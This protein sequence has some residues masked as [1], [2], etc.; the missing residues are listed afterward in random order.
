VFLWS[1]RRN[2]QL[3]SWRRS[4]IVISFPHRGTTLTE[5]RTQHTFSELSTF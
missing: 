5:H 1:P 2:K 4:S 3:R